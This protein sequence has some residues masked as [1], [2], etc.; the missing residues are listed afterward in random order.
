[1]SYRT[2]SM[3]DL[4]ASDLVS[5]VHPNYQNLYL[6]KFKNIRYLEVHHVLLVELLPDNDGVFDAVGEVRKDV[7]FSLRCH[8]NNVLQ[9]SPFMRAKFKSMGGGRSKAQMIEQKKE[10]SEFE[11]LEPL[12]ASVVEYEKRHGLKQPSAFMSAFDKDIS[13]SSKEFGMTKEEITVSNPPVDLKDD[14]K[15]VQCNFPLL[16]FETQ[17]QMDAFDVADMTYGDESREKIESYGFIKPF[18]N[19]MRYSPSRGYDVVSEDQFSLPASEHFKRMRSLGSNVAYTGKGFSTEG[20]TKGVFYEMVDKFEKNEGGTYS[21]PLLTNALKEHETTAKFHEALKKCLEDSLN[22]GELPDDIVGIS[23][24]YLGKDGKIPSSL[25]K[26]DKFS[27]DLFNGTV[28]TVH[29]VWSMRVY[30]EQLEYKGS[31]VRG[32]FKYKVQDHFGLDTNDINHDLSDM[33]PYELIDGF[34]SWYLLQHF[35]GYSFKPF[36]T[37]MDFEL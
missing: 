4:N 5:V 14:W 13:E 35:K 22:N 6:R 3:F 17:N 21:N 16:V 18:K 31:Q 11:K 32:V 36:I 10:L 26:F 2:I 30:V 19:E 34:R 37:K 12:S 24:R 33:A 29:D 1:M 23:S 7:P 8:I 20:A 15:L 28:L 25:P 9:R 27:K